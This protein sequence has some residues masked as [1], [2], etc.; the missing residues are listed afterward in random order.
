VNRNGNAR[1][2]HLVSFRADHTNAMEEKLRLDIREG[3]R[4]V[5]GEDNGLIN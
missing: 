1:R 3:G 2:Q 5:G 4:T